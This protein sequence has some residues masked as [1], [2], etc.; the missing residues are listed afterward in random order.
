MAYVGEGR[1]KLRVD[2]ERSRY[3][4]I[5]SSTGRMP[6]AGSLLLLPENEGEGEGETGREGCDCCCPVLV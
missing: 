2:G 1:K 3:G 5:R 4:L 6:A